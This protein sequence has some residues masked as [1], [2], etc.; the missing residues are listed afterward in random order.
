MKLKK[1]LNLDFVKDFEKLLV[2]DFEK[3]LLKACLRNYASHGNPLRFHNFAFSMRELVLHVIERNGPKSKVKKAV[4]YQ[5]DGTDRDV[6]RRQQIKY[7]AQG[8]LSDAYLRDFFLEDLNGQISEYLE[9]FKFFNK[10][11]HI[12]EK[13]Y[14]VDARKFFEDAKLVVQLS[15]CMID[16]IGNLRSLVEETLVSAV[17]E[18]I[19][20]IIN[21]IE[22]AD[23]MELANHVT[24]D[25][26]LVNEVVVEKYDDQYV[27]A[28][29]N[30]DVHVSQQYGPKNDICII[31]GKYPFTLKFISS[32]R[33]PNDIRPLQEE[34][35]IDTSSWYE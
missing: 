31:D 7:C 35:E 34:L 5:K 22:S 11:T 26:L 4:W 27:Y 3:E 29:A 2:T 6:T 1:L 13:Y 18:P 23:L 14:K 21:S 10:Y 28:S 15:K 24:I 20:D 30:G 19:C 32:V 9:E 12:T 33:D 8:M 16:E 25:Y 17:H